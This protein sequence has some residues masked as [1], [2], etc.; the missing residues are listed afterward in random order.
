MKILITGSN[1]LLGQKLI[2][3]IKEQGSKVEVVTC[4]SGPNRL[5][6]NDFPYYQLDISSKDELISC[7]EKERPDVIINSAA[8]TNV[9]QCE[10]NRI[11]CW[12]INVNAVE[13]MVEYCSQNSCHLV[14]LSTDFIFDGESG[15]Y[16]EEQEGNP[17]SH[18][19]HSK[20]AAEEIVRNSTIKWSIART[21]LVFGVGENLGRSNIVLWAVGAMDKGDALNIVD[22]QFRTP[23]LAEDL[24]DGC[25]RIALQQKEGIFHLSGPNFLS[26]Y[27]LVKQVGE[28]FG[29]IDYPLNRMNSETL[30][31]AAKR[32][33][34]TGFVIDK[35]RRV[36]GYDPLEFK[37]GL[38]LV[39][40]QLNS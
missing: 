6:F 15:P 12:E 2:K 34:V 23:T 13:Y 7:L 25:L 4:S 19:G 38:L 26:I 20:F 1:G 28:V 36:L 31:Q 9:D 17:L 11:R 39:K 10:E 22:D 33:P 24:A 40:K 37:E 29:H 18:Y 16:T 8:L 5:S 32:P 3:A 27:D 35:A 30:N 14:Q 21:V